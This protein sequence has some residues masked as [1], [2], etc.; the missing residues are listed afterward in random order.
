MPGLARVYVAT[1]VPV[2]TAISATGTP[3]PAFRA[4]AFNCHAASRR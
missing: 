1:L 4:N 2:M 3:S